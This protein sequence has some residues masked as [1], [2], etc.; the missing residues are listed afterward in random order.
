MDMKASDYGC[1]LTVWHLKWGGIFVFSLCVG[2]IKT[3]IGVEVWLSLT[4]FVGLP[5]LLKV[6]STHH[7]LHRHQENAEII[8]KCL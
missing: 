1:S 4:K 7:E 6:S 3:R 5:T 8:R 2:E